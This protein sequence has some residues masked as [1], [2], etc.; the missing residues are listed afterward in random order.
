ML[1]IGMTINET[2]AVKRH[3]VIDNLT[4]ASTDYL[5]NELTDTKS[6]TSYLD[7]YKRTH[8]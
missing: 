5:C 3:S 7:V 6:S 2:I 4:N 8:L 1:Q